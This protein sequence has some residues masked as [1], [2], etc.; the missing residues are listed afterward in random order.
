M[1]ENRHVEKAAEHDG[2]KDG[3]SKATRLKSISDCDR[4]IDQNPADPTPRRTKANELYK[5]GEKANAL[6]EFKRAFELDHE[7]ITSLNNISTIQC[8]LE[9][10]DDALESSERALKLK[11]ESI[12]SHRVRSMVMHYLKRHSEALDAVDRAISLGDNDSSAYFDKGVTLEDLGRTMEAADAFGKA[13]EIAPDDA[14]AHRARAG[15]LLKLYHHSEA[16]KALDHEISLKPSHGAY[17]K[18]A[19]VLAMLG[20]Y[21]DAIIEFEHA[22]ELESND[23]VIHFGKSIVLMNLERHEEALEE[24][25]SRAKVRVTFHDL[26]VQVCVDVQVEPLGPEVLADRDPQLVQGSWLPRDPDVPLE[27]APR[28]LDG[29]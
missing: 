8:D 22:I 29:A 21:E 15:C 1:C 19:G 14:M 11:P 3:G 2:G 20:K 23:A 26:P 10:Y 6:K 13:A 17:M 9:L 27:Y 5:L 24:L 4:M 18:K 7:D 12:R 28:P 16:I 25:Y